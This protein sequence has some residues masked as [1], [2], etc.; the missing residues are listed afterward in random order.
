MK[1]TDVSLDLETLG[2]DP[3][4][5]VTQIGAVAF[6]ANDT[7]AAKSGTL[8]RI[9]PQSALDAGMKVSWATLKWWMNQSEAARSS[10][11]SAENIH[12]LGTALITFG[13]WLM[14]ETV[15]G[16]KDPD[17]RAQFRIWGYGCSFD[18][19]LIEEAFRYA[20]LPVPWSFRS[21]YDLRT[22]KKLCE[23]LPR[24]TPMFNWPKPEVE[25]DALSD[26]FAQAEAIQ[27]AVSAMGVQLA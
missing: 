14:E 7:Q 13:D 27:M 21:H 17:E 2:T 24:M 8:I 23:A 4:S 3:G 15:L 16:S 10:T 1:C 25:H 26:A 19:V 18:C 12:K 11:V 6:N 22:L 5:V 9:D 20:N